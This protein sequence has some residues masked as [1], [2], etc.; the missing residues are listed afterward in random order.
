MLLLVSSSM[1]LRRPGSCFPARLV[2]HEARRDRLNAQPAGELQ[3]F[4]LGPAPG[5]RRAKILMVSL[6][7]A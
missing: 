7:L 3:A 6:T 4:R 1:T 5:G 2:L